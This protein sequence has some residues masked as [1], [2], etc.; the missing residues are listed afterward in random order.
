MTATRLTVLP[1]TEY[2]V[3]SGNYDGTTPDFSGD[4]VTAA[5]YYRAQGLQTVRYELT[6]FAGNIIIEATLDS[7]PSLENR[8]WFS[9]YELLDTGTPRTINGSTDVVG[10]FTW[11]RARVT[12][13]GAGTINGIT[14]VY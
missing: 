6:G 13:F 12:A 14:L 2:G 9:V 3:P 10:N 5:A 1:L 8:N 7:S 4:P 11:I